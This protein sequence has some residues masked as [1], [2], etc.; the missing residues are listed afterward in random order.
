MNGTGTVVSL[1]ACDG[2]GLQIEVDM[3]VLVGV[4][5]RGTDIGGAAHAPRP[6]AGRW[7]PQ[8]LPRG[9]QVLHAM[10]GVPFRCH[11]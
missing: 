5:R 8:S 9:I 11:N 4:R 6:K 10:H 1:D 2:Y 3:P 7:R